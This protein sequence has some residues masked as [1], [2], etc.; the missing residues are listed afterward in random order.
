MTIDI[1][2]LDPARI[3]FATSP[4]VE[5]GVAPHALSEPGHHPGVHGW[6]TATATGPEGI[7]R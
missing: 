3:V 6:T 2:G 5:P 1:A 4:L 7:L